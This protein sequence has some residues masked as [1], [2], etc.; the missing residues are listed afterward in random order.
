[1]QRR[2]CKAPSL[3]SLYNLSSQ[4]THEAV[5]LLCQMLVFNPVS[6]RITI[7]QD[8]GFD[9]FSI[10]Q[11]KRINCTN[12]LSHPYLEEGRLRYHSCMCRCCHNVGSSRRYVSDLEPIA[13]ST[14][15]YSFERELS[16]VHLVKGLSISHQML[17]QLIVGLIVR[18]IA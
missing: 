18:A 16:S 14:F 5:H 10:V 2:P 13:P 9:R 12:A 6:H 17:I 8:S 1:M 15:D 11:D 7:R 4:A 3:G